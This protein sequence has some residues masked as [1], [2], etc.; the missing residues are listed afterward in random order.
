[1][2]RREW[3]VAITPVSLELIAT[4]RT[5]QSFTDDSELVRQAIDHA[6]STGSSTYA[7]SAAKVRDMADRS[8]ALDQE[9]S[10]SM[11]A[12]STAG[13]GRD[14]A[15]ASAAGAAAGQAAAEQKMIEMETNILEQF[16]V[17]ERDQQGFAT[18]NSLLAV[19][20]PMRN[21]P[22]RKRLSSSPRAWRCRHRYRP[23][24]PQ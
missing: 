6:T 20:N 8:T 22:G 13:A 7:S 12:A 21:L 4:L 10:S 14:S 17:L 23:S 2:P 19:I 24:F 11:S 18:I 1:M 9:I 15:G 16:Q 3:R 5:F